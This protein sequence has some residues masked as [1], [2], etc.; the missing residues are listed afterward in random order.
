MALHVLPWLWGSIVPLEMAL[1]I[2]DVGTN[3][4]GFVELPSCVTSLSAASAHATVPRGCWLLCLHSQLGKGRAEAAPSPSLPAEQGRV[5]CPV[6]AVLL[7]QAHSC[8][9]PALLSLQHELAPQCLGRTGRCEK[10]RESPPS[11]LD[12]PLPPPSCHS[13]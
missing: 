5:P 8:P 9:S 11:K 13:R 6:L 4:R 10:A 12:S 2:Q 1:I 7:P 3:P